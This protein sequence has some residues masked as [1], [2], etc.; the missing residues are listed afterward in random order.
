[1]LPTL[2]IEDEKK[3]RELLRELLEQYCSNVN[4]I[5]EAATLREA[6]EFINQQH[7]KLVFLDV[8]MR[9]GTG[10]ELLKKMGKVDFKI[11]FVTA[12]AHYAI[13]AIRFS[14]L[15]FLLKP[16]DAD[17]LKDAV[18]KAESEILNDHSHHIS[19]FLSNLETQEPSRLAICIKDGVAFLEPHN[20]IRLQADGTYTHIYTTQGKYTAIKNLKEYEEMLLNFNFFRSHH[21][22]L[23]NLK[24]VKTFNRM[25]GF[26]AT[27][28]DGTSV[29]I[30]RRKKDDFLKV[31]HQS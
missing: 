1:M 10:F 13:K 28:S 4:V 18:N 15:D 6:E 9:D 27:M 5:G 7:P 2:I 29:E 21:S 12:H 31:M 19:G 16:I 23:I 14:A 25:D 8:E 17:E 26:F 20:I 3:S 24:H 11:I 30:S 22:H